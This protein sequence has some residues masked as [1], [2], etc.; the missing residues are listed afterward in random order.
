MRSETNWQRVWPSIMQKA[1]TPRLCK[2]LSAIPDNTKLEPNQSYYIF[3]LVG[4]GKTVLAAQLLH[5]WTRARYM[6]DEDVSCVFITLPE[7][8]LKLRDTFNPA[9]K[10]TE[11]DVITQY[12]QTPFLVLDDFGAEKTSEY[13]LQAL[14][15]I[16]NHRYEYNLPTVITSNLELDEL[17]TKLQD[18]RIPSRIGRMC[19]VIHKKPF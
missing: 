9:N 11:W 12:C 15:L 2:D 19:K 16:I 7:L 8:L 4:S 1:L 13:V 18:D 3:G 14:Y 10:G 17:A 6:Q 5:K